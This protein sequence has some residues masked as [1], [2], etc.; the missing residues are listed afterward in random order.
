VDPLSGL[1][2]QGRIDLNDTATPSRLV[3][4]SLAL[5]P[6]LEARWPGRPACMAGHSLAN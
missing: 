5:D 2:W 1:C 3:V 6:A 4:T